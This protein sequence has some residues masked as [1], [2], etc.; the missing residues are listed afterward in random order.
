MEGIPVRS[1]V[2]QQVGINE[3]LRRIGDMLHQAADQRGRGPQPDG[4]PLPDAEQAEY[5]CR[6][7]A[8]VALGARRGVEADL[9]AGSH[10][11]IASRQ[12]VHPVM[13]VSQPVGKC[14]NRSADAAARLGR[15]AGPAAR[16]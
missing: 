1:R 5:P 9:K 15:P 14:P 10:S 8:V 11:Q 6:V 12:L 7:C 13:L 4:G 16:H 2:F 3:H